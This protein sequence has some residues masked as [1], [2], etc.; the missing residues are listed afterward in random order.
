MGH[1][2]RTHQRPS[3]YWRHYR[4]PRLAA[5]A[6]IGSA[7]HSGRAESIGNRAP[8]G[9]E[10]HPIRSTKTR[11]VAATWGGWHYGGVSAA[12]GHDDRVRTP[13]RNGGLGHGMRR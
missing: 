10:S 2:I 4:V 11:R 7:H 5:F 3:A 1:G 13:M 9:V 6:Q 12:A 8:P